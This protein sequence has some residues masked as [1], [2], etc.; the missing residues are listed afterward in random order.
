M[1]V[2]RSSLQ[3][4]LGHT[5]KNRA[6]RVAS[7]FRLNRRIAANTYSYTDSDQSCEK[8]QALPRST[9]EPKT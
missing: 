3:A 2:T 8:I 1:R 4:D 9:L 7:L 6:R 5:T